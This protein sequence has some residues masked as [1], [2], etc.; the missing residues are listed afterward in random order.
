MNKIVID[1]RIISTSTGRYIERLVTNLQEIDHE[2]QYVILVRAKDKDYWRPKRENFRVQI[3]D[4]ADFSVWGE[5]VALLRLLNRLKPDLVHFCM[6]QQPILYRGKKVTTIHDLIPIKVY[7]SDKQWLKYHLK[8][9][10][11]KGVI[12]LIPRTNDHVI[13]PTKYVQRDLMRFAHIDDHKITQAYEAAELTTPRVEP[14]P[15]LV[16]KQFIMYVGQQS[17]YKNIRRL[18]QAHQLLLEKKPDLLLVLVG[19]LSGKNGVPLRRNK[20]WAEEHG[21]KNILYTDFLP[22]EQLAWTYQH[23]A[24][25]VFPSLMEGFGLP[26][27]EAMLQGAPVASSN[28]T[29]LPEVYEDAAHYFDP[30]RSDDIARAITEVLDHAK[31]R[32]QLIKKGLR[33]AKKYS[34]RKMAEETLAVY[35]KTL[36]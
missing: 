34:W 32:Q 23:T 8:Q 25:Y 4:F 31:L 30:L 9:L 35:Q 1:A 16:D 18:M 15:P 10:V 22:D 2:N 26:A 7:N 17:D 28:A 12:W 13:V 36:R 5:Q 14:Y 11:A 27:L 33:Q 21:F 19:K 29:C 20:A 6:P 24:C 3:A